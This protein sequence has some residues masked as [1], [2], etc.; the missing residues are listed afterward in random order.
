MQVGYILM[1]VFLSIFCCCACMY[2]CSLGGKARNPAPNTTTDTGNLNA[3]LIHQ[4][5]NDGRSSAQP[6]PVVLVQSPYSPGGG[7]V[8]GGHPVVVSKPVESSEYER[9]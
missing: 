8:S 7:G 2:C 3:Y 5:D 4:D 9:Y 6:V 1:F